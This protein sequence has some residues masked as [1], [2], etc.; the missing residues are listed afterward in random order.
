MRPC[1][2]Y[3]FSCTTGRYREPSMTPYCFRVIRGVGYTT[4]SSAKADTASRTF[5]QNGQLQ[6]QYSAEQEI[7]LVANFF[8]RLALSFAGGQVRALAV[9][10]GTCGANPC[11]PGVLIKHDWLHGSESAFQSGSGEPSSKA[12]GNHVQPCQHCVECC[13][14][15]AHLSSRH[16]LLHEPRQSKKQV[17]NPRHL[18]TRV[19]TGQNKIGLIYVSCWCSTS[20]Q[21]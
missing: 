18:R 19:F 8:Y 2:T 10:D 4:T 12:T 20:I 5:L 11:L 7:V 6:K 16:Q 15:A 21:L 13:C 17:L 3:P 14:K 9:L 1:R